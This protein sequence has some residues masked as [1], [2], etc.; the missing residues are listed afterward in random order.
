LGGFSAELKEL[1]A[2]PAE[3][4]YLIAEADMVSG[5]G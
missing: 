1:A 5:S 2:D 3:R 4:L